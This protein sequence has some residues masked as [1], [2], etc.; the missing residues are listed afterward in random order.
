[1]SIDN[2]NNNNNNNNMFNSKLS[3]YIPRITME[4]A[5]QAKIATRVYTN[6]LGV[7]ERVDLVQK[8]LRMEI[9]IAKHL[10]IWTGLILNP[11]ATSKNESWTSRVK[12][13]LSM[14]IQTTGFCFKT[15]SNDG[16]RSSP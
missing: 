15:K 5:E 2:N 4:W 7:V 16:Y 1:M 11:L 9:C 13:V 3:V 8:Q 12:H 6:E 14:K 10:F